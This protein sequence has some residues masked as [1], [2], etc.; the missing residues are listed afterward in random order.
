MPIYLF[1]CGCQE[2]K[3]LLLP[4]KDRDLPRTCAVCNQPLKREMGRPT[5]RVVEV[6]DNGIMAKKLERLADAERLF[7]DRANIPESKMRKF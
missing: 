7:S 3:T 1:K 4:A 6:I 2:G 5:T